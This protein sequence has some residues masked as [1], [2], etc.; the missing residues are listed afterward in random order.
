MAE[1]GV[2]IEYEPYLPVFHNDGSEVSFDLPAYLHMDRNEFMGF[3]QN[4]VEILN[5]E[6]ERI[7]TQLSVDRG[8]RRKIV[9][10]FVTMVYGLMCS[11]KRVADYLS[12]LEKQNFS[13]GVGIFDR[14]KLISELFKIYGCFFDASL[15]SVS[16]KEGRVRP[17]PEIQFA[18]AEQVQKFGMADG[19]GGYDVSVMQLGEPIIYE[20]MHEASARWVPH[21]DAVVNFRENF[22]KI[23]KKRYE[24]LCAEGL[25]P[26]G[27]NYDEFIGSIDLDI[28]KHELTHYFL[29]KRYPH[30]SKLSRSNV[31]M[32]VGLKLPLPNGGLVDFSGKMHPVN[33]HELCAV[34]NEL[35]NSDSYLPN[36]LYRYIDLGG[37]T[38]NV[39]GYQLVSRVL[40]LVAVLTAPESEEKE[41]LVNDIGK[42][43]GFNTADINRMIANTYG[44]KDMNRLGAEIFLIGLQQMQSAESA[45]M[46]A[47][48]KSKGK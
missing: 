1:M 46:Q 42:R 7:H 3:M 44:V 29:G 12:Y 39:P 23:A 43:G 33:L 8:D 36:S 41:K 34:G 31:S 28:I 35:F 15:N 37:G 17:Y 6:S 25:N 4:I 14:A 32:S 16:D 48:S 13:K 19:H 30:I 47:M 10:G 45:A 40:P 2:D 9:E 26:Y 18:K 11:D 22:L 38:C 20:S 24:W 5:K 27:V 21:L